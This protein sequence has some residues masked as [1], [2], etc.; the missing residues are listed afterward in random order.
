M[1][2][3]ILAGGNGTRLHPLTR[4][5][6]KQLLPVYDKPLVFHPI[7]TL[8]LAGIREILIITTPASLPNFEALL[9]DGKEWGLRFEYAVQDHPRG[10]ADAFIIGRS[11][12]A[13]GPA[14]LALGDN[15]FYAAGLSEQLKSAGRVTSGARVFAYQVKD[16]TQFGVVEVDEGGRAISIVEKPAQPRSRWAVTGLYFYGADVVDI[17]AGVSPS[18][19]G[20]IE[21]TAVNDVYLQRGQLDVVRLQRGTAWLDAGTFDSLLQASQFVQT[22][23]ARQN[24]KIA[25]PEEVAWRMGYIDDARLSRL[26]QAYNND[27]RNYLLGLLE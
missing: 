8:M 9:G 16:P 20:E 17:A 24:L 18:P 1:K 5:V 14:A 22:L 11:F 15:I 25:C 2:G 4:A 19:R 7:T 6:S 23:E 3:I 10:L 26:A 21:I 12:L 27:Y 13:G